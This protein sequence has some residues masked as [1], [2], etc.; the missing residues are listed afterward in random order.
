MITGK[1]PLPPTAPPLLLVN[2][3]MDASLH[4]VVI[5]AAAAQVHPVQWPSPM[6]IVNCSLLLLAF[7]LL[8]AC[9]TLGC[10]VHL[11]S[12]AR[13]HRERIRVTWIYTVDSSST[14][15][16]HRKPNTRNVLP[17]MALNL[18]SALWLTG[19]LMV[20]TM[21][22]YYRFVWIHS[23]SSF[24]ANESTRTTTTSTWLLSLVPLINGYV[25]G[26]RS[27]VVRRMVRRLVH[28][29]V[30]QSQWEDVTKVGKRR[31]RGGRGRDWTRK[32]GRE[33]PTSFPIST[34]ANWAQQS[35]STQSIVTLI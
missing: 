34:I 33:T 7:I 9:L 19:A 21:D 16:A 6:I 17:T 2:S 11:M 10:H 31:R 32:R 29:Y 35:S 25:Y 3:R 1:R 27:R 28:R 13:H 24:E 8:P 22:H 20:N 26:V 14:I 4:V 5:A 30:Q 15:H 12:I 23:H 18:F